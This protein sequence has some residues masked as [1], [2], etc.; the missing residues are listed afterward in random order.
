MSALRCGSSMLQ[1]VVVGVVGQRSTRAPEVQERLLPQ[2]L[3]Q[4]CQVG[5]TAPSFEQLQFAA[6]VD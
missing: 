6:S 3:D 5:R 1:V 2:A 4:A